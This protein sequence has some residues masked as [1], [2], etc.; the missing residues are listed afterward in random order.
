MLRPRVQAPPWFA[1]EPCQPERHADRESRQCLA[2][3]LPV[4]AAVRSRADGR[5][6]R[7]EVALSTCPPFETVTRQDLAAQALRRL[8]GLEEDNAW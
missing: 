3:A 8:A 1:P 2:R 7:V 6:A 5:L 4:L